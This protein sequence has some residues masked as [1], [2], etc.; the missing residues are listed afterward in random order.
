MALLHCLRSG[1]QIAERFRSFN[2]GYKSCHLE[3]R[4][5]LFDWPAS[6]GGDF[7]HHIPQ[8]TSHR[9]IRI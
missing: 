2:G 8:A 4:R 6:L 3:N 5:K 1:G 9:F 7:F